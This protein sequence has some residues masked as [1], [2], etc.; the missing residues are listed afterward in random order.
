MSTP[1]H[2]IID[3]LFPSWI[4]CT[5]QSLV[6]QGRPHRFVI[7]IKASS[8]NG[9]GSLWY[10]A[11]GQDHCSCLNRLYSMQ[12]LLSELDFVKSRMGWLKVALHCLRVSTRENIRY[13]RYCT[14]CPQY[15]QVV[16]RHGRPQCVLFAHRDDPLQRSR[17]IN[18]EL[19]SP[20]GAF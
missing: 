11:T 7:A 2:F 15:N 19:F 13:T 16:D 18:S 3:L 4:S 12:W 14:L 6:N 5:T 8:F 20:H 17:L 9:T 10:P 1:P